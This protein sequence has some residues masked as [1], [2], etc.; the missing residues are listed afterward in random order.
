M[1]MITKMMVV[2]IMMV[3]VVVVMT[4]ILFSCNHPN[5]LLSTKFKIQQFQIILLKNVNVQDL[6]NTGVLR[7]P[8][9]HAVT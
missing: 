6:R 4:A 2:M 9:L 1:M 3:V 5:H 8:K 7:I